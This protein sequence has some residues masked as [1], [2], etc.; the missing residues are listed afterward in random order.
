M[1]IPKYNNYLDIMCQNCGEELEAK[2]DFMAPGSNIQT[3][4]VVPCECILPPE[5]EEGYKD[6]NEST[7]Q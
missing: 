6:D 1:W 7:E 5:N 2:L 4:T 3:L